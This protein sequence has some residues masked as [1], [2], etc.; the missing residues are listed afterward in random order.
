MKEVILNRTACA[1]Q[2]ISVKERM[3]DKDGRYLVI[4]SHIAKWVG[5]ATMR[6][7]KFDTPIT[8]WMQLPEPI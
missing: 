3:P 1:H 8:H 4:E 7:G 5:V 2:W 6:Q